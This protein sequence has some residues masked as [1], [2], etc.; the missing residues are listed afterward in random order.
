M[1]A[2][3]TRMAE[4]SFLRFVRAVYGFPE[5]APPP[6]LVPPTPLALSKAGLAGAGA[7][8]PLLEHLVPVITKGTWQF[9]VRTGGY[10]R[11]EVVV[12]GRARSGRI[13][14]EGIWTQPLAFGAPTV[15]WLAALH[16]TVVEQ[17]TRRAAVHAPDDLP[18]PEP[19]LEPE[20]GD[21]VPEEEAI[22]APIAPPAPTSPGDRLALTAALA[23][24]AAL[25][26]RIGLVGV[27]AGRLDLP[28]FALLFPR[29]AAET[30]RFVFAAGGEATAAQ[31][32]DDAFALAWVREILRVRV[33]TTAGERFAA[34][35]RLARMLSALFEAAPDGRGDHLLVPLAR[36]YPF[37]WRDLGGVEGIEKMVARG[38]EPLRT[39]S[40]REGWERVVGDV[41][42]FGPRLDE[43][44]RGILT[45]PWPDRTEEQKRLVAEHETRYRV[46]RDEVRALS[47]RLRREVG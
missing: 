11:K 29:F 15:A 28:L 40:E 42:A 31:Y 21:L 22:L 5:S 47:R 35:Q 27:A 17:A 1:S 30:P 20:P 13:W 45:T 3:L 38:S 25:P 36:F 23:G 26:S 33:R 12:D 44:V 10:R 2:P 19:D 18:E 14:D 46:M 32:L 39:N 41:L 8:R 16:D 43:R 6:G 4:W 34:W 24:L 7:A 37:L 9:L